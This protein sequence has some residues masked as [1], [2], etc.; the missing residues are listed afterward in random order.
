VA[1]TPISFSSPTSGTVTYS[2]SNS[3][4]GIGLA[5]SGTTNIPVFTPVNNGT[6]QISS[7]VTVTPTANGCVGPTM[8]FNIFVDPTP[9]AGTIAI[10]ASSNQ[11]N[12]DM[13]CALT[14]TN[15]TNGGTISISGLVVGTVSWEQST[16]GGIN[17]ISAAG[18]QTQTSFTV[19]NLL[20]TTLYR[21]VITSGA[22]I[23]PK[24]SNYVPF[25]VIPAMTPTNPKATPSTVCLGSSSVL[26]ADTGYPPNGISG[27][28]GGF[29][30]GTSNNKAW[31]TYV[32]GVL[33]PNGLAANRDN[34]VAGP[35]GE[36][37]GPKVFSGQYY[38][39]TDNSKFAVA[40][41]ANNAILESSIFSLTGGSN[42]S[43]SFDMA[44]NLTAN[45]LAKVQISTDGG[46]TYNTTLVTFNT[47]TY[48]TAGVDNQGHSELLLKN[49]TINLS[50]YVGLSNL[51]IRFNYSGVT[52]SSWALDH[53]ST[54]GGNLPINYT[55]TGSILSGQIGITQVTAT[56]QVRGV[57]PYNLASTVGGCP[58]GAVIVNVTA[59]APASFTVGGVDK[60]PK[61]VPTCVG[62]AAIITASPSG[63]NLSFNWQKSIDGT[64]WTTVSGSKYNISNTSD[65]ASG[66]LRTGINNSSILTINPTDTSMVD[67]QYKLQ[68][69]TINDVCPAISASAPLQ[70][71]Y[72]W[73]GLTSTDWSDA[74][75]WYT[76]VVPDINCDSVYILS[77]PY[78]Y[79]PTVKAGY[80]APTIK[81]LNVYNKATVTVLGEL[82][83]AD[84]ISHW[85]TG[86]LIARNGTLN[87][88]GPDGFAQTIDKNTFT[89][90]DLYN[91]NLD[92]NSRT[93]TS[94]DSLNIYGTLSF[95]TPIDAWTFAG[96]GNKTFATSDLLTLKSNAIRTANV[97]DMNN[98]T[99]NNV[100][101]I[102]SGQ[103]IVERFINTGTTANA[104]DIS[105][106]FVSAPITT[107]GQT[108]RQSW[109]ENKITTSTGF[110]TIITSNLSS[111]GFDRLSLSPSMKYYQPTVRDSTGTPDSWLGISGVDLP[112]HNT[113]GYMLFVRGDRSVTATFGPAKPTT[114][115]AKGP[116][117]Q[118]N[119]LPEPVPVGTGLYQS[120]GNPYASTINLESL[121]SKGFSNLN[122]D[123]TV[124]DPYIGGVYGVGGY[125]TLSAANNYVPTASGTYTYPSNTPS[126]YIQSGQ[127]FFVRSDGTAAGSVSFNEGI[128]DNSS[129]LV[130]RVGSGLS[131]ERHYFRTTLYNGTGLVKDGNAVVFSAGFTNKLDKNDAWKLGN[132]GENFGLKRN[133][134]SLAVEA[135]SLVTDADTI[136]YNMRGV[137][138]QKYQLHFAP[139]NMEDAAVTAELVDK[140]LNTRTSIN[141]ANNS[142][143]D[144]SV[145]TDAASKASDRFMVVFK[146]V[147]LPLK[148]IT[149]R[150]YQKNIDIAVNWTV[151]N[152]RAVHYYEV[153]KSVDGSVFNPIATVQE[154]KNLN[155]S[156]DQLDVHANE[157]FNYYRIKS[158]SY[159]GEIS[160]SNVVKVFMGSLKPAIS[161]YPNPVINGIVNL[162][163]NNEPQGKYSVRL[164]NNLGQIILSQELNHGGGNG[165]LP[166]KWN[167]NLSHGV[168]QLEVTKPDKSVKL[169]RVL[170]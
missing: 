77:R 37:N 32:N 115:R 156:Y 3:N 170:Y 82:Q 139:E 72:V 126:P 59:L 103:A 75:N 151:Q 8:S 94:K 100:G 44:Y 9:V 95:G 65:P 166:I 6:T 105:W 97:A 138:Q 107:A 160:Y 40:D 110:G 85:G 70:L 133:G 162:Q 54:P 113:Q 35:W 86:T 125:Q 122:N 67:D 129:R 91:L 137:S 135:R 102:I 165:T 62:S 128:K 120:I 66:D 89:N 93:I 42:T 52:G 144:F 155:G 121:I 88:N 111:G 154:N 56:P 28:A 169:I 132:G 92:N 161:I 167:F 79:E 20:Q 63:D 78:P 1:T 29:D 99:G 114:L 68:V 80:Q 81:N 55:W 17:W 4:T 61:T 16:D 157:G 53:L 57:N 48:G 73:K 117:Y 74:S 14:N 24:Y 13:L 131:A 31:N 124:W 153:E 152:E 23:T 164:L 36:T 123:V 19:S 33:D 34:T 158:V 2:W 90:N 87:M 10:T 7:A 38:D 69:S 18:A 27:S 163:L 22:C 140:F 127:A 146:E 58:G 64:N 112:V 130:N 145:T 108:I 71:N 50:N 148:F 43:L 104:H 49:Y 45:N 143:Y 136:F 21:A 46:K 5:A 41:G 51:R 47:G 142:E 141:L 149:V 109:M 101:N 168:Y 60:S 106:Q 30:N 159:T 96:G 12:P 39:V 15:L 83:I 98:G 11:K 150:A 76:N 26:T 116:L 119:N 84:H 134:L 147:I 118:S 25:Q